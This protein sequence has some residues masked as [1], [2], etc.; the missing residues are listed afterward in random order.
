V[1]LLEEKKKMIQKSVEVGD[2]GSLPFYL[3]YHSSFQGSGSK[4]TVFSL[5]PF[6]THLSSE[7]WFPDSRRHHP[8][9][10]FRFLPFFSIMLLFFRLWQHEP[11][12]QLGKGSRRRAKREEVLIS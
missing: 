5:K 7:N 1:D 10:S 8:S 2:G 12:K 6:L 4:K 3:V 11:K 9:S